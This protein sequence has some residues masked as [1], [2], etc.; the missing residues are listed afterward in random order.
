MRATLT[1]TS[2]RKPQFG[3]VAA[4]PVHQQ[5]NLGSCLVHIDDDFVDER[6]NDAL[7]QGIC[8]GPEILEP[9]CRVQEILVTRSSGVLFALY[10]LVELFL[11]GLHLLQSLIPSAL[12]FVGNRA[13]LGVRGIELLLGAPGSVLSGLQV[14]LESGDH[15]VAWECQ[16]LWDGPPRLLG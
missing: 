8:L 2:P 14:A 9:G 7:S 4:L 13:V 10:M 5:H 11:Y 1:A 6:S 3:M 16:K 12:E 15:L